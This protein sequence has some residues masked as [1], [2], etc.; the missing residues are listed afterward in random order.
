MLITYVKIGDGNNNILQ[1]TVIAHYIGIWL[2]YMGYDDEEVKHRVI[3]N[4]ETMMMKQEY[5]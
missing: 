4:V 2:L 3:G 1:H 5:F